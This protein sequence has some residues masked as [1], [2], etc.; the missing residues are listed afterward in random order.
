MDNLNKDPL[1]SM[2]TN[3]TKDRL[4]YIVQLFGRLQL[5]ASGWR[6]FVGRE[7]ANVNCAFVP[8]I[9]FAAWA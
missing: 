1:M 2:H 9:Y 4:T 5:A 3:L 8:D 7:Y 6:I